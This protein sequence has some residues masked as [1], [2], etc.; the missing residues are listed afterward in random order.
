VESL[1]RECP[2]EV[3]T[4]SLDSLPTAAQGLALRSAAGNGGR[5]DLTP[6]AWRAVEGQKSFRK[7]MITITVLLAVVWL[8]AAGA[9]IGG[10]FLEESRVA[11]LTSGRDEMR[12]PAME[13]RTM[14]RRAYMIRR[15]MDRSDSALECLREISEL[16]PAGVDLESFSYRK[17]DG[18]RIK[19]EAGRVNQVYSFKSN[20]DKSELFLE[21]KLEG[22]ASNRRTGKQGFEMELRLPGGRDE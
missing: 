17:G 18:V 13:V 21:T 20:L 22:P 1:R 12:G 19:G 5:L 3:T 15:Y 10:L 11:S 9:L 8:L 7:K 4:A 2:C 14:R 16:Q 6:P